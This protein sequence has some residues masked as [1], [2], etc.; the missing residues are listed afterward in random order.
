MK[1]IW[2][3]TVIMLLLLALPVLL[4]YRSHQQLLSMEETQ[5][6]EERRQWQLIDRIEQLKKQEE[7][8]QEQNAL[9]QQEKQD[10]V[11]RAEKQVYLTFDDGPSVVTEDLL[12]LLLELH[13]KATFFVVG[14]NPS[15]YKESM[16]RRIVQEGHSLGNHS[17]S[18][19]YSTIY[20]SKEAFWQDF[21]KMED[22]LFEVTGIRPMLTR[23]P[24][25]S[26]GSYSNR[27]MDVMEGLRGDMDRL[28]YI[29]V[30]WN[31]L[32]GDVSSDDPDFFVSE[33]LRQVQG[34]TNA[35]VLFHDTAANREILQ[36]IPLIVEELRAQ[37]YHFAALDPKEYF[38][39][40]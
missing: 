31:V 36:A 21:M 39:R 3:P 23:F 40:Y 14:A 6:Q 29:Y 13:I 27:S 37:G 35:T 10:L 12:A 34:K 18:H 8:L 24:G 4:L 19:R 17:Y 5:L 11:I 16:M 32:G 33:V 9:L 7:I 20:S 26:R 1:K 38:V 30:D 15:E 2:L 22:Y 25:G 28:G